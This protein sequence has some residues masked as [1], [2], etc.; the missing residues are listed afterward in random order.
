MLVMLSVW[1]SVSNPKYRPVSQ[2]LSMLTI[3]LFIQL[4]Q[5]SVYSFINLRSS[6]V[7]EFFFQVAIA[8]L[9]LPLEQRLRRFMEMATA[10][11]YQISKLFMPP[12]RNLES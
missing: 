2:V 7:I 12:Q 3:I 8:L 4:V 11:K 6:P 9:V 5:T 10:G 1:L